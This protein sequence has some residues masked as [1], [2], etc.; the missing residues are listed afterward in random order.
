MVAT[1]S[2]STVIP[3]AVRRLLP[4]SGGVICPFSIHFDG[5]RDW[6]RIAKRSFMS[7]WKRAPGARD[8]CAHA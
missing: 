3:S 6:L 5:C 1:K 7:N 4:W 8:E 2:A